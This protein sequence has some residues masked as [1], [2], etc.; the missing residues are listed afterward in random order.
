M[1]PS[2]AGREFAFLM[3]SFC[4]AGCNSLPNPGFPETGCY[5]IVSSN[6]GLFKLN[7]SVVL[8]CFTGPELSPHAPYPM[9]CALL[10]VPYALSQTIPCQLPTAPANY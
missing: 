5:R 1:F 9:P 2:S 4:P 7:H 6:P 10:P 8:T 3:G